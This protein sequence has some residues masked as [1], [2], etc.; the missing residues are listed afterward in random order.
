MRFLILG[1]R[2]HNFVRM[3]LWRITCMKGSGTTTGFGLHAADSAGADKFVV[4][5]VGMWGL[6][7]RDQ[8]QS[9][10]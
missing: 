3:G 9:Y 6:G 5:I 10:K 1:G 7:R 4:W 8:G 2:T